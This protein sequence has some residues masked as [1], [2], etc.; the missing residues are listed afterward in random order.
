[1]DNKLVRA[2]KNVLKSSKKK[3]AGNDFNMEV[4]IGNQIVSNMKNFNYF[5]ERD[6]MTVLDNYIHEPVQNKVCI[7]YG[8]RRTGK[9][10]MMHQAIHKMDENTKNKTAFIDAKTED[11][12][13]DLKH[14]INILEKMGITN[15]F[16]DEVTKI[17]NFIDTASIFSDSF[18]MKGMRFILSGTDSLSFMFA[19][20]SELYDRAISIHTTEIPFHEFSRLT[21]IEDVNDYICYGGTLNIEEQNGPGL[22]KTFVNMSLNKENVGKYEMTAIAENIQNSLQNYQGS[23]KYAS[24]RDLYYKYQL[25]DAIQR[26]VHDQNHV[27]LA[28]AINREF[29]LGEWES[30]ANN[31]AKENIEKWNQFLEEV[32]IDGLRKY[33]MQKLNIIDHFDVQVTEE[34][35]KQLKVY[36]MNLDLLKTYKCNYNTD[37]QAYEERNIITQP[38]LK[39]AQIDVLLQGLMK[40]EPFVYLHSDERMY[41]RERI[42]NAIKGQMLEDIIMHETKKYLDNLNEDRYFS[43]CVT[44]HK[45][46]EFHI[47]SDGEL[48][49]VIVDSENKC[50][51]LYEIKFSDYVIEQY[52]QHLLKKN[53]EDKIKDY[54]GYEVRHK[55]LLYRGE[56][57]LVDNGCLCMNVNQYLKLIPEDYDKVL[58]HLELIKTRTL[59]HKIEHALQ[60]THAHQHKKTYIKQVNKGSEEPNK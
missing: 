27:F 22:L 17:K 46:N 32:Q 6:C 25:T 54:T 57:K 58:T 21:G 36:M 14:D 45:N 1:M 20:G 39:Y 35:A 53:Y 28:S 60:D 42:V 26:V 2:F 18:S 52:Y 15:V 5:S 16:I 38:G 43:Q 9:T 37:I 40:I 24:L 56:E 33:F 34:A 50:C 55:V 59:N 41:V 48:D 23:N 8:L 31:L 19:M 13:S 30:F 29:T 51:D 7:L 47:N 12:L 44:F 10:V 49:L 3:N 4:Y 11:T